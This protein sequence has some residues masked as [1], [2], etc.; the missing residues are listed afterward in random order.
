MAIDMFQQGMGAM[1]DTTDLKLRSILNFQTGFLLFEQG[2]YAP[3]INYFKESLRL[4]QL[5]KDTAMMAFCYEKLAYTYEDG[6][7]SDSALY[8][9]RAAILCAMGLRDSVF[10]K[11]MVASMASYYVKSGMYEQADSCL[12]LYGPYL[13]ECDRIPYLWYDGHC[14]YEHRAL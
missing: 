3:A 9:H 13:Q 8:Y 10:Y 2:V 12:K 11:R 1:A 7:A 14:M 5:R 6:G 4:E